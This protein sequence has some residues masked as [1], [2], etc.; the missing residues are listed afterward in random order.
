VLIDVARELGA[1]QNQ[2]VLAWLLGGDPAVWP[3]VGA[4]TPERLDEVMA[5]R[6]LT[7]DAS[8]RQ[9]LDTAA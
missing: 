4:S 3:I 5:A 7:F 2:T 8:L 9:R 6:D 1:T